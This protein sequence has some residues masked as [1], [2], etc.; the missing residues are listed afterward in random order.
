M[1]QPNWTLNQVLLFCP[2]LQD[3]SCKSREP[4]DEIIQPADWEEAN[5]IASSIK[6]TDSQMHKP[7]LDIDL[8]CVLLPSS[9]KGHFHLFIDRPLSRELY[10]KLLEVLC[11]CGI[12]GRGNVQQLKERE[13]TTIRKPGFYKPS[14]STT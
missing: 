14:R 6:G 11:E 4:E 3:D 7:I 12:I 5:L 2:A 1:D 13:C 8:P 10:L 9:T